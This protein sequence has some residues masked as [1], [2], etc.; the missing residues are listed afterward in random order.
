MNMDFG[1]AA[2]KKPGEMIVIIEIA[3]LNSNVINRIVLFGRVIVLE[4]RTGVASKSNKSKDR[5][6]INN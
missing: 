5:E 6:I 4:F 1:L 2:P 3:E